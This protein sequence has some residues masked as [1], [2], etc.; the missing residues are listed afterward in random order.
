MR[1]GWVFSKLG[2]NI[3]S[4]MTKQWIVQFIALH[5]FDVFFWPQTLLSLLFAYTQ[6]N[7]KDKLPRGYTMETFVELGEWNGN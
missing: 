1:N 6:I 7:D 5:G 3:K 4:W 2:K